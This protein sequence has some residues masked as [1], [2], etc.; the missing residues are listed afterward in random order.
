MYTMSLRVLHPCQPI[1]L[2]V[3][4]YFSIGVS[5]SWAEDFYCFN[6]SVGDALTMLRTNSPF[7]EPITLTAFP[8]VVDNVTEVTF[9]SNG[10]P[11]ISS[12]QFVYFRDVQ[13]GVGSVGE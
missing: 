11:S 8:E 6:E 2:N 13:Y 1:T 7:N 4:L 9:E 10:Q 5:V 3:D 12:I